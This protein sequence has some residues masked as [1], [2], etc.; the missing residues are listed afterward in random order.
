VWRAYETGRDA[1]ARPDTLVHADLKP[2]HVCPT[3]QWAD[4]AVL[5][6]G[7]A[8]L[9]QADFE[10]ALIGLFFDAH[11]RDEVAHRL[12]NVDVRQ[13]RPPR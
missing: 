3:Q 4:H 2:E 9:S 13:G 6:W 7:D 5:D 1:D 11:V 10:L 8:C 12:P